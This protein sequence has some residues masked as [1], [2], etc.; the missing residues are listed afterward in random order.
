MFKS[1]TFYFNANDIGFSPSHNFWNLFLTV[2]DLL[3]FVM[4]LLTIKVKPFL[5]PGN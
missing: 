2:C 3:Q 4:G 1:V 5:I